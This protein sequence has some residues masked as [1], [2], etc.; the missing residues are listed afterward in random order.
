MKLDDWK[1]KRK[2]WTTAR[3]KAKV[4]KGA[5]KGVSMGD[6]IEAIYKA[7]QKNLLALNT[8]IKELLDDLKKYKTAMKAKHADLVKWLHQNVEEPAE[9]IREGLST[10]IGQLGV[11]RQGLQDFGRSVPNFP[12]GEEFHKV[13]MKAQE[14]G[15]SWQGACSL[16]LFPRLLKAANMWKTLSKEIR[17]SAKKLKVELP[18]KDNAALFN[19][20]ADGLDHEVNLVVALVKTPDLDSFQREA[21]GCRDS[22]YMLCITSKEAGE[23]CKKLIDG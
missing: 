20:V 13:G 17:E 6:S 12:D 23:L 10:D 11:I 4:S 18:G 2:E 8:A 7:S 22:F 14:L 3:D 16:N 21:K 5:V 15:M 1:D 9:A 19:K